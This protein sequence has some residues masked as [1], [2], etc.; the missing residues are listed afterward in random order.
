M[1]RL[2]SKHAPKCVVCRKAVTT[3]THD[4]ASPRFDHKFVRPTVTCGGCGRTVAFNDS[5]AGAHVPSTHRR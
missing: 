2:S 1:A 5:R 3:Q 4:T